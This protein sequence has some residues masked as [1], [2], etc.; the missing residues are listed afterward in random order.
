MFP[1]FFTLC[2][3]TSAFIQL[4][5]CCTMSCIIYIVCTVYAVCF[6]YNCL[7]HYSFIFTLVTLHNVELFYA[8]Q[9]ICVTSV[10]IIPLKLS[11]VHAHVSA[12]PRTLRTVLPISNLSL[13]RRAVHL[14]KCFFIQYLAVLDYYVL[15]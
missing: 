4:Y 6:H 1:L 14:C 15:I 10:K 7:H 2:I 13:T 12:T 8:K 11:Y 3:P 5:T 9:K